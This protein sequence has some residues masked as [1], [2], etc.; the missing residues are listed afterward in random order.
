[1]IPETMQEQIEVTFDQFREEWLQE[2]TEGEMAPL[3]KGRRFAFKMVTQWLDVNADDEDLVICDGSGDGGIDIAYLR[4]A[5]VEVSNDVEQD[6]Q[7]VDGDIWYLFQSK[8]GSAFQGQETI[9]SEGRK[10]FKTLTGENNSLSEGARKLLGRLNTFRQQASERDRIVLVFATESAMLESDRQA[11]NDLRALGKERVGGLFDVEDVSLN[12]IWEKTRDAALQP[13][14][15]LPIKGNFVDPSSGLRV[16]TVSLIDLYEFL[17][18]YRTKTGNLDQLYERN[19]RQ[20]LGGRRKIN[21]GIAQ[22]LGN[23][24]E[25]FGLYNNGITIVVSDYSTSKGDDS[26][27]LFDPFVVNGCQTTKTIWEELSQRLEAGG[28]GQNASISEWRARAER[29]VVVTKIVKSDSASINDITRYTNSQNAVREQDFLA[30]R[31]DFAGWK[32]DMDARYDIFLEIQR[33]GW[34]SRRAYQKSHPTSKQFTEFANAFDL[35]KVY[36]A[37]WLSE[38]GHAFGRSGPFLPGGSVFRRLTETE[39]I[40]ADDL[41]AAYKLQEV[42][43][44]FKFG[45]GANVKPSRRQTRFIYFL[46]VIE[47]LRDVLIREG[48]A[49]TSRGLT[50]AFLALLEFENEDALQL[51]LEAAIEV[52]DEYLSHESDDSV[53]KEINFEG[54]LN[55]WFKLEALGKGTEKTYRLNSLLMAHK[56]FFGRGGKGQPSPRS[57]V[58]QEISNTRS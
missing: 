39:P 29:G 35:I 55:A 46:V 6:G 33:G 41:Y 11:L 24:P 36:G 57:L 58:S 40:G 22:T 12:T 20:F 31:K 13:A 16:G 30:L 1:M 23:K 38:P 53:F 18:G 32:S 52:V 21:K 48:H 9:F 15:S 8:Y 44:R 54:D 28:T 56:N 14:L 19:V 34:D 7:S 4:R 17:K 26:C 3:E 27:L 45:R 43:S 42:S 25:I 10:V 50:E 2:F 51:L 5:E 37:G 49:H 47:L